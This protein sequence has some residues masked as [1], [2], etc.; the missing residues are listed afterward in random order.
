MYVR[1]QEARVVKFRK[2]TNFENDECFLM[3]REINQ[4]DPS[5]SKY[6]LLF[7][8][9]SLLASLIVSFKYIKQVFP[10]SPFNIIFITQRS[11]DHCT[12]RKL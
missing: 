10:L 5:F 1:P 2:P 12:D 6:N 9:I 4:V 8:L 3:Y 7:L 11:L